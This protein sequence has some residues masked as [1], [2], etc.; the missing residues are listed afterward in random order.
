[1]GQV[2]SSFYGCSGMKI[3]PNFPTQDAA[4]GDA[5]FP[6]YMTVMRSAW[7]TAN[8]S[9]VFLCTAPSVTIMQLI[10]AAPS[11]YTCSV[12]RSASLL[13]QCMQPKCR[14]PVGVMPAPTFR[15]AN[16]ARE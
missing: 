4:L 8:E 11:L 1:M 16:W 7:G 13:V 6:G 5:D 15:S 3:R 10:N 9:A 2:Y 12:L 14:R